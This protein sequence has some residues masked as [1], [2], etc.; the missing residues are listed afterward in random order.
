MPP[1]KVHD[2]KCPVP[3]DQLK[4]ARALK[5]AIFILQRNSDAFNACVT[6]KA[7]ETIP[8]HMGSYGIG[9]S[10]LVVH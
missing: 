5:S 1:K 4:T 9:V 6:G 7:G 3:E 8:L 2:P 10:R